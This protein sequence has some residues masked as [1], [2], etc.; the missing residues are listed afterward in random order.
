MTQEEYSIEDKTYKVTGV[1][2]QYY[3]TC[4]TE[5]WYF[6]HGINLDRFNQNMLIGRDINDNTY[7]HNSKN[8]DINDV[9]NVDMIK[10]SKLVI[11]E[12]KKSSKYLEGAKYQ[13]LYYLYYLKNKLNLNVTGVLSIPK[14]RKQIKITLG[15]EEEDQ[16]KS[17]INEIPNVIKSKKP[18]QPSKKPYC[19]GCSYYELCWV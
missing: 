17:I 1:M 18:L 5:L 13:L 3:I 10:K 2:V 6:S 16:I 9:I 11:Y 12:I 7:K 4:K 8:I 19:K 14:E 15:K